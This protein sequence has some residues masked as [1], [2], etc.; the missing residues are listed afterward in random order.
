MSRPPVYYV[1]GGML[2][3]NGVVTIR[4]GTDG[5][6][7]NNAFGQNDGGGYNGQYIVESIRGED[8]VSTSYIENANGIECNR[9]QLWHGRQYHLTVVDDTGMTPPAP[10]TLVALLDTMNGGY[11]LYKF[12]VITNGD[13]ATAKTPHK[14]ELLVEY[15]SAVEGG[16]AVPGTDGS[17]QIQ[18]IGLPTS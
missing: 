18:P 6:A 16:G 15:L 5:I 3:V 7:A 17:S 8:K 12:V 10:G 4:W 2:N 1:S 9:I 14:R 11:S 13:N